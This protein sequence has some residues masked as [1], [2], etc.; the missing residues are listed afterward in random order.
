MYDIPLYLQEKYFKL[1]KSTIN[2]S[3]IDSFNKG[4]LKNR[5][6]PTASSL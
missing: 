5:E 3:I 6:L 4:R 1:T 2:Y